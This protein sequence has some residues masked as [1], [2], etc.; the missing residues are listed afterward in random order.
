MATHS[1]TL[2]WKIRWTEKPGRLW[3]MGSQRVG[4]DWVTSLH[5][6][7]LHFTSLQEG[8]C[9]SKR[10]ISVKPQSCD[11]DTI[12]ILK[13]ERKKLRQREGQWHVQGHTTG[14]WGPDLLLKAPELY[15][16]RCTP[17]EHLCWDTYTRC[18][19]PHNRHHLWWWMRNQSLLYT[20]HFMKLHFFLH[21]KCTP[22]KYTLMHNM[23][24][25]SG[26]LPWK[27]NCRNLKVAQECKTF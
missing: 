25:T 18:V 19:V 2:A 3:S 17:E 27:Y 7:S 9:S 26:F 20:S 10:K 1:S 21:W 6:T 11:I 8:R 13:L 16:L 14:R 5:F 23:C 4:H 15:F 22:W 12:I 24:N